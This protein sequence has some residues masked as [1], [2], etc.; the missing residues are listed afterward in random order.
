MGKSIIN[1]TNNTI[2]DR[3]AIFCF[4][5]FLIIILK[6]QFI[7]VYK[8]IPNH[9]LTQAMISYVFIAPLS[10]IGIMISFKTIFLSFKN[11]SKNIFNLLLSLPLLVLTIYYFFFFHLK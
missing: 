1:S 4:I 11:L 3:K 9:G 7:N 5:V 6:Y 2:F 10:L 8:I